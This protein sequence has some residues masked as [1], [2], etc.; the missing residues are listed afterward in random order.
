MQKNK[1]GGT[2]E[3]RNLA[4]ERHRERCCWHKRE[5]GN[6]GLR[7]WKIFQFGKSCS[8]MNEHALVSHNVDY[9]IETII[10]LPLEIVLKGAV[11]PS[12]ESLP[13]TGSTETVTIGKKS[14]GY[15]YEA[16]YGRPK[17]NFVFV[18]TSLDKHKKY[19]TDGE[20]NEANL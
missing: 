5:L 16:H 4:E 13:C 14:R 3:L 18:L 10:L 8:E 2:A 15:Y 17:K 6:E 11:I 20:I 9:R 7:S 1:A 12:F 19:H